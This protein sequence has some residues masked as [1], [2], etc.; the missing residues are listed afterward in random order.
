[1]PSL[2]NLK[3]RISSIETTGKITTAMKLVATA[4]LKKQKELYK[5]TSSYYKNF[6]AIFLDLVRNNPENNLTTNLS[7]K[8]VWIVITSSLGLCG[9]FNTQIIKKL[10]EEF[11]REKDEII[12]IGRK[13][14]LL[15]KSRDL[16]N[17]TKIFININPKD[18]TYN[19][20]EL[21]IREFQK[22][23]KIGSYKKINLI[24]MKF[25]N[26]LSFEPCIIQ[27]LPIEKKLLNQKG[28]KQY[29]NFMT[30]EPDASKIIDKLLVQFLSV[31]FHGA[32]LE[33]NVSENSSRRNSM[34]NASKNADELS[35]DLYNKLNTLRQAKITQEINEITGGQSDGNN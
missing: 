10:D 18:I 27:L 12:L 23:Y 31:T 24:Y 17:K 15:L 16:L 7:E 34:E 29:Q 8:T 28:N 30:Y 21:L 33:S 22:N 9:S 1:M 5:N 13:G 11:N 4:N 32:I 25:I 14:R 35:N 20:T 2:D 19:V 6:H 26:S 3:K